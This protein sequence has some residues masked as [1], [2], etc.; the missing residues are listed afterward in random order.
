MIVNTST[1]RGKW[2]SGKITKT[3]SDSN[4]L[5]RAVLVKT[6]SG[7][8][9]QSISKLALILLSSRGNI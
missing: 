4:G 9:K 6:E 3:F 7:I 1:P 8:I 2:S 5:V